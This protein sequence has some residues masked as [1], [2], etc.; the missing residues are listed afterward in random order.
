MTGHFYNKRNEI[1]NYAPILQK[2][3]SVQGIEL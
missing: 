2:I 1:V 3:A